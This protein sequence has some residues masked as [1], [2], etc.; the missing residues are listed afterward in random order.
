[1]KSLLTAE[2]LKQHVILKR[3]EDIFYLILNKPN[4]TFSFDFIRKINDKLDEIENSDGGSCLVSVSTDP[5]VYSTGL[6]LQ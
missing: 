1:M 6:D 4:N 2:D 3:K 5:K